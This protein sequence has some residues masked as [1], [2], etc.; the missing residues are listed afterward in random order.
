MMPPRFL[1]WMRRGLAAHILGTA[2]GGRAT[3]GVSVVAT[4]SGAGGTDSEAVAGPPI[5]L[6]GPGDVLAIDGAE[7]VRHDPEPG[8]D[9][10]EDNYFALVELASPDLPWR[11]TPAAAD[12]DRLLPWITLVVVEETADT[13]LEERTGTRLPV[14]HVADVATEL[15]RSEQAWAWAHVTAS[16]DLQ[17]S[18][19]A[20]YDTDPSAFR[21][22]LM[23][24]RRLRPR[25][26][27][28][29][30]IVPTFEAGRLA[31]LGTGPE[32][33]R[34]LAWESGES[35][36][37]DLPVYHS[38]RFRTGETGDFESLVRRL[39]P[40]ELA[41]TVGRRDLDI[42]TPGPGLPRAPGVLVSY[43]GALVSTDGHGRE[44]DA[45]H[46]S[47][48]TGALRSRLNEQLVRAAVPDEYSAVDHDPVVGPP[49]Y[50]AAQ[51]GA[52]RV[53][54]EDRPPRWFG[55]LNTEPPH[56]V[57]AALGADVVR[58][59]QEALMAAAWDHAAAVREVNS[60]LNA[61]RLAYEVGT[62]A[63]ARL[64]AVS[65]ERL[66]Q[67]AGP[68]ARRLRNQAGGTVAAQI[69]T[70]A[71]RGE[72]P[73]G[74]V[75]GPLRRLT[76]TTPGMRGRRGRAP[77]ALGVR[78]IDAFTRAVLDD[79]TGMMA[80]WGPYRTPA[81]A[82]AARAA[83]LRSTGRWVRGT[84]RMRRIVDLGRIEVQP[85]VRTHRRPPPAPGSAVES[86]LESS[87]GSLEADIR[88]ALD[89][90]ATV[91]AMVDAR[92]T[93]LPADR[94]HPVPARTFV[95]PEFTM[96]MYERL[97]ALSVEYLVPGVGEIPEDT[98]GLLE[99]N[100]AFIEAFMAGAN[101]EM[102]REFLW[103]EYPARL[104]GTWFQRFWDTGPD[105]GSDIVVIR[106]W[107]GESGLGSNRPPDVPA[108]GLVL[109]LKGA[110]PRRYPDL[111]VYATQATWSDGARREWVD[112]AADT[113]LP[114]FSG[115]LAPGVHF[116]GFE[117][118]E[119]Q[120]RGSTDESDGD[121][122]YFFVLEEQPWA[123]RFGL[124]QPDQRRGEP[125]RQWSSLSWANLAPEEGPIPTFVDVDGPEWLVGLELSGNGGR[126]EW[127]DDA[128][129]MA[130]ITL[131]RPVRMLVHADAML[132]PPR[133]L[134][135][136]D[137]D[138]DIDPWDEWPRGPGGLRDR[139]D[140]RQRRRRRP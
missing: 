101:H 38:W 32:S 27:W 16:H 95:R 4:A 124:D 7:V 57:V 139:I 44:W 100:Q 118:P 131:Q 69:T 128:A 72:F 123:S 10:A 133:S 96:P 62:R 78:T 54:A 80:R 8:A 30:C 117:L 127:G 66:V 59:D 53:P 5:Q 21:A 22:R 90:A 85:D 46:R 52:R 137:I 13:W 55:E 125:P 79:P 6:F 115:R 50:A 114:L 126:D 41:A 14:L 89:P 39:V 119:R 110:L 37:R 106:R 76:H 102:A 122:G 94:D 84:G 2:D 121:A 9:D 97:R 129:A 28:I 48:L 130:R 138:I 20:A 23:C 18:V 82:V 12:V 107:D 61:A 71:L 60:T 81:V 45:D 65:G 99:P 74:L 132:P 116:Y 86:S 1:P 136:I 42:G 75:A 31:G 26:P 105:G 43:E 56:R 17:P 29:A 88:A 93:G 135:D 91:V 113:Q 103:R 3:A 51:S 68:A 47:L 49:A 83:P 140:L 64:G 15:P 25:R 24:P 36:P 35:G 111:R 33:G 73:S 98:L 58:N 67:L 104:D 108:A 40:R 134:P 112:A 92:V 77:G 70:A 11:F 63:A 19:A 109:L 34:A 120:A 87:V